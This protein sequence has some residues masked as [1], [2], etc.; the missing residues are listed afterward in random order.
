[1]YILTFPNFPKQRICVSLRP[2]KSCCQ[3]GIKCKNTSYKD[4]KKRRQKIKKRILPRVVFVI[5]THPVG[6]FPYN[7]SHL[8]RKGGGKSIPDFS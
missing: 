7:R 3:D 6:T 4:K 8:I 2:L 1:M 5:Y